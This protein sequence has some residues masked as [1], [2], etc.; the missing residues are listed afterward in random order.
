[1]SILSADPATDLSLTRQPV[2]TRPPAT[3]ETPAPPPR[4]LLARARV[5]PFIG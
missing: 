4:R 1:M 2:A 5:T 3:V